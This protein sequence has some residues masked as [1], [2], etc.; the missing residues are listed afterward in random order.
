MQFL[1]GSN[2]WKKYM[3]PTVKHKYVSFKKS[4]ILRSHRFLTQHL[5]FCYCLPKQQIII[6]VPRTEGNTIKSFK[7][8]PGGRKK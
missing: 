4:Q 8:A 2:C 6:Q 1:C 7:L 5:D 3:S